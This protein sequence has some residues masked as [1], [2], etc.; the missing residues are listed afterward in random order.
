MATQI[1]F[2]EKQRF[3]QIWLWVVLL[4]LDAFSFYAFYNQ[5]INKHQ[6]GNRPMSNNDLL[7]ALVLLVVLTLLFFVLRLDTEINSDG[8]YVRFYPFQQTFKKYTWNEMQAAFVRQYNPIGDYG[9]RGIRFGFLG[10]GRA[11]NIS[12]NK[13]IQIIFNDN[14]KLLIGTLKPE[15]ASEAL[16]KAGHPGTSNPSRAR[17]SS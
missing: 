4:S 11:Y 9:G 1:F 2:S 16:K 6:F 12:G 14:R 13:G 8:I 10:K 15:E 17:Y 3:R 7:F 5:V